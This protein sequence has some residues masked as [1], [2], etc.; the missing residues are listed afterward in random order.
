MEG[1][2]QKEAPVKPTLSAQ[3]KFMER[4]ASNDDAPMWP[5]IYNSL[6]AYQKVIA[7]TI[8]EDLK[9]EEVHHG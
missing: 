8:A 3:I 7:E 4:L 6:K 5:A 1:E 2:T 9:G